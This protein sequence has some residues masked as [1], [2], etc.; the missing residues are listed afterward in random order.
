MIED[1]AYSGSQSSFLLSG[2]NWFL[3]CLYSS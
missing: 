2:W 1:N 3:L